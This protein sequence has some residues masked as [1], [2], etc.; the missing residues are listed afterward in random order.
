ML[1]NNSDLLKIGSEKTF[2]GRGTILF[3]RVDA[4]GNYTGYLP[5][6]VANNLELNVK[7]TVKTKEGGLKQIK[8]Q[9]KAVEIGPRV[10]SGKFSLAEWKKG[11][12]L[13]AIGGDESSESTKTIGDPTASAD[14]SNTLSLL[15]G[16][17]EILGT[18]VWLQLVD[19]NGDPLFNLAQYDYSSGSPVATT[20]EFGVG[21]ESTPPVSYSALTLDD[22]LVMDFENGLIKVSAGS[23]WL[24]AGFAV[25]NFVY[26]RCPGYSEILQIVSP[27][28]RPIRGKLLYVGTNEQT[29]RYR[30]EAWNV[31]ISSSADLKLIA[32]DFDDLEFDITLMSDEVNHP[33]DP[34][35]RAIEMGTSKLVTRSAAS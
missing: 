34:Y 17:V 20:L 5:L 12:L 30:L 16:K 26:I 8:T 29:P 23:S 19:T 25:G 21:T 14:E 27:A 31:V 1:D 28:T 6:G 18:G 9:L 32:D 7:T 4:E 10:W 33:T 3:D 11:N 13:L 35:F 2:L 15:T 24:G 22:D